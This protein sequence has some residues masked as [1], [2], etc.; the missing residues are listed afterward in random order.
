MG[1]NDKDEAAGFAKAVEF[2]NNPAQADMSPEKIVSIASGVY[3]RLIGYS[4]ASYGLGFFTAA[5][6][7]A[8]T[9]RQSKGNDQLLPT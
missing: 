3:Q 7:I 2:F 6:V 8:N 1:E 5:R 9:K 4:M